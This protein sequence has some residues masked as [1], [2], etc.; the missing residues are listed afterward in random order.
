M[1]TKMLSSKRQGNKTYVMLDVFLK[2]PLPRIFLGLKIMRQVISRLIASIKL[3]WKF[4]EFFPQFLQLRKCSHQPQNPKP[5]VLLCEG[6]VFL[7]WHLLLWCRTVIRDDC[8]VSRWVDSW[9]R[10][11]AWFWRCGKRGNSQW[12]APVFFYKKSYLCYSYNQ[13]SIS[14]TFY[15]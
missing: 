7:E 9:W 11:L 12:V 4:C 5:I 13:H 10:P 3:I 2:A 15:N 1:S 6:W 14:F 8:S